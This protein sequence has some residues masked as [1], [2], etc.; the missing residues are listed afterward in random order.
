MVEGKQ[1]QW[2]S[3]AQVILVL[4]M[5]AAVFVLPGSDIYTHLHNAWL[6]NYMIDNGVVLERDFSMLGGNQP[7]YGV[8]L[9]SYLLAGFGWF[10]LGGMVVK[11]L[12]LAL[13]AGVIALSLALFKRRG[14]L[15][16]WY[17]LIFVK[18]L[19]P[20]SYPYMFSVFLFYLGLYAIKKLR[21]S[22]F[23]D[24][25]VSLAGLNHPYVAASN[26]STLFLGRWPLFAGSVAILVVQFV[27]LKFLFFSG[28]VDFELDNIL[29]FAIRSFVMLF[30]FIFIFIPKRLA[31]F[32]SLRSAYLVVVAGIL[33]AYPVFFVP[34]EMG[35]KEGL[36]CYYSK[37]YDTLPDLQG[38][39]RVVDSCRKWIYELPARGIVS[40][41][42]PYFEGQ[43]YQEE[44]DE[45]NYFSYLR[46][47]STDYVVFCRECKI[48]TKTLKE[49]GEIG[50][51]THNFPV[52]MNAGSYVIF[53]VRNLS[54]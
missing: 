7:L 35:W 9:L 39:V 48:K 50:I 32:F 41:L 34:F 47:S 2:L 6:Y 29:D 38:N 22:P 42:S 44:W 10:V 31:R 25:A 4:V 15:F 53:D 14:M 45:E 52:Y 43:H 37:S 16:F 20:D 46:D 40:S 28:G 24:A 54:G 18:I 27:L 23:G 12:E 19:L 5:F 51:L 17:G 1:R 49:T 21:S 30:P 13:F 33:F 8:G 11:V 36:G 26:L 3:L